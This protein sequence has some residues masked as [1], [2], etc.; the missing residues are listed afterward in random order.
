MVTDFFRRLFAAL[1]RP[2]FALWLPAA[3][4][5]VLS[6]AADSHAAS[7]TRKDIDELQR[8][9][10]IMQSDIS[11]LKAEM[12]KLP[13]S[14]DVKLLRKSQAE[15]LTQ[16]QDLLREVQVL[17]GR[18]EESRFYLDRFMN[19]TTAEIDMIKRKLN[20][21]SGG[22]SKEQVQ[23]LLT[24]VKAL[25]AEVSGLSEKL[26]ALEKGSTGTSE[27]T[28]A[29]RTTP[30]GAEET[31]EDFYE[32]ALVEFKNNDYQKARAMMSEFIRKYP[33]NPL[34]GNAQ[35][36]IAETYYSE[37]D[38]TDAI[39][40]YED[41]LQKYRGHNKVPAALL[42][43]GF[44]FLEL[45]DEKAARGILKELVANYPD[46]EQAKIAKDKLA[47]L[48]GSG[49]PKKPAE[50]QGPPPKPGSQPKAQ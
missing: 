20:S 8:N 16:M 43:Q 31:P 9:M 34:A 38:Y 5:L 3:A 32:K 30:A 7:Q 18:Y 48:E 42:K 46:S 4:L 15:M 11:D 2:A 13:S 36:W 27:N 37:K 40:A 23:E 14:E 19:E 6:A 50:P 21:A 24:R 1:P 29:A 41:L 49:K 12:N 47:S 22:M 10:F 44:A 33:E 35:F 26:A 39:L 45:G 17:T 28:V 25:E